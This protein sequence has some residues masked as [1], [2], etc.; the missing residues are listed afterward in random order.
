MYGM[1]ELAKKLN[2]QN[3]ANSKANCVHYM[4]RMSERVEKVNIQNSENSTGTCVR[5][6]R[7]EC[8]D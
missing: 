7:T 3:C 2:D 4:Y 8:L 5:Y 6:I 1:F